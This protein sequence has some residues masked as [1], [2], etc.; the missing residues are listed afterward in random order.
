MLGLQPS[1]GLNVGLDGFGGLIDGETDDANLIAPLCG[2]CTN[3]MFVVSHGSLARG[4]PGGPE[5]DQHNCALLV[6]DVALAAGHD[7]VDVLDSFVVVSGLHA[8]D[9]FLLI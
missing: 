9:I 7:V 2:V 3:D 6:L 4:A 5:V 8:K 1:L